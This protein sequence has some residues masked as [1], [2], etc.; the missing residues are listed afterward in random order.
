MA[1]LGEEQIAHHERQHGVTQELEPLIGSLVGVLGGVG[2]MDQ[3]GV[4][5]FGVSEPVT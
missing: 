2:A 3:G 4:Q 1:V 5:Q